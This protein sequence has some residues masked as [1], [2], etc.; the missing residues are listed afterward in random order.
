MTVTVKEVLIAARKLI[1]DPKNW[2]Q[3]VCA[4]SKR[5][6]EVDY[7]SPLACKW[8]SVGAL[9]KSSDNNGVLFNKAK[10]A[11]KLRMGNIGDFNDN[12]PHAEILKVFDKAIKKEG[13]K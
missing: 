6:R 7:Y 13:L 4:R 1:E 3:G 5:G 10:E 11:L 12:K 8:C 2:T 9:A